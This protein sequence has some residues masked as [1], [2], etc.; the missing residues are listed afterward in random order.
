MIQKKQFILGIKYALGLVIVLFLINLLIKNFQDIKSFKFHMN[1]LFMACSFGLL[2]LTLFSQL[3]IWHFI[4]R[5]NSIFIDLFDSARFRMNA[6][7]GKYIPGR[8]ALY[9]ILIY[10]YKQKNI[11]AERV[12]YCSIN[13]TIASITGAI[14][15]LL[16][17]SIFIKIESVFYSGAMKVMILALAIGLL[18]P[19]PQKYLFKL[20][21]MLTKN[22]DFGQSQKHS[23]RLLFALLFFVN[24]IIF[25]LA[26]FFL[27][28][29]FF[30][31]DYK[32]L[33]LIAVIFCLSIFIGF[34]IFLV[35]AGLG[36]REG[37]LTLFLAK[38]IPLGA[39]SFISVFS[40]I[41]LMIGEIIL[42]LILFLTGILGTR[43]KQ[44]YLSINAPKNLKPTIKHD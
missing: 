37:T 35:P 19:Q 20:F 7:F 43:R 31:V 6:E 41:W 40:R 32:N 8:M 44:D 39:A 14:L 11:S 16:V 34:L 27:V 18:L 23:D 9:G 42:F 10:S 4:T 26:F 1:F 13:E 5:K 3:L 28:R 33:I 38:I 25:G 30:L 29:A 12:I 21:S 22:K 2:M 36:I 17:G 15:F 24:W